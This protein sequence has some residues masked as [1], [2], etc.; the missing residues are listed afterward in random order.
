MG[1]EVPS[2]VVD[3]EDA[4]D[5]EPAFSKLSTLIRLY[6]EPIEDENGAMNRHVQGIGKDTHDN[7]DENSDE[8]TNYGK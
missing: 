7:G 1:C 5:D 3:D 2:R 6:W 4:D 8:E